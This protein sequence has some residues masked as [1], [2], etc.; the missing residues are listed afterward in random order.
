M[1][2]SLQANRYYATGRRKSSTARVFLS[3]GSGKVTI[4]G[5]TPEDY[6]PREL[7]AL[8][9]L[10]EDGLVEMGER[11]FSLT[12]I[13]RLLMRNVGM[14]FDAYLPA[15]QQGEQPRFSRAV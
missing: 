14:C 9:P 15:H 7:A 2:M 1:S 4:N 8:V 12:P 10:A 13:G 5:R 6:F 3:L 11:S